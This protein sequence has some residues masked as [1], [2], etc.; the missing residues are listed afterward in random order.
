MLAKAR[1]DRRYRL[2]GVGIATMGR[3]YGRT[4]RHQPPAGASHARDPVVEQRQAV[5]NARFRERCSLLQKTL[6]RVPSL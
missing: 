6:R 2:F 3:S 4:T 1:V 5:I